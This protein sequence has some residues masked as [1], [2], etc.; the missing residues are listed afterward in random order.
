MSIT[1][2]FE[3]DEIEHRRVLREEWFGHPLSWVLTT[4]GVAWPAIGLW[5]GV[6]RNWGNIRLGDAFY[7]S[8]PWVLL[9]A[10]LLGLPVLVRHG[11]ASKALELDP[12][13]NGTQLRTVDDA[14]LH[15]VGAGYSPSLRWTDLDRVTETKHF[16]LF[17]QDKRVWHYIPK[18]VLSDVERDAVRNLIQAHAPEMGRPLLASRAD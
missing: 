11:Q 9:G 5:L 1:A 16:F 7:D 3:F 14:G 8:M 12:S 10:F 13:L 2:Q 18:G 15:I 17:F 6:G 4:V